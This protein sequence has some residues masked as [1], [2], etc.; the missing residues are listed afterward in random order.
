MVIKYFYDFISVLDKLLLTEL[1]TFRIFLNRKN[2]VRIATFH[3]SWNDLTNY[4]FEFPLLTLL[5]K[6]VNFDKKKSEQIE[7][8]NDREVKTGT[9]ISTSFCFELE[10]IIQSYISLIQIKKKT[11]IL[12]PSIKIQSQNNLRRIV[13]QQFHVRCDSTWLR[14]ITL[15]SLVR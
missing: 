1:R 2:R 10:F 6:Y 9:K 13:R 3:S 7:V 4:M 5:S 8:R 12:K 14:Y 11:K 15:P